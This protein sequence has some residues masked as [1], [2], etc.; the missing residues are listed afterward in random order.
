[1][2]TRVYH[3]SPKD[4]ASFALVA[5]L[6]F[7]LSTL[8][9]KIGFPKRSNFAHVKRWMLYMKLRRHDY[10]VS[11][12]YMYIFGLIEMLPKQNVNPNVSV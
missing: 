5:T 3:I 11:N 12:F 1:M 7:A 6:T 9:S 4:V 8:Q 2:A 10:Q